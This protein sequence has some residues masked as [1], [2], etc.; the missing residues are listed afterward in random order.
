MLIPSIAT[1]R[2]LVSCVA[3]AAVNAVRKAENVRTWRSLVAVTSGNRAQTGS[4]QSICCN[5]TAETV[6]TESAGENVTA[7]SGWNDGKNTILSASEPFSNGSAAKEW[8]PIAL[9]TAS[10]V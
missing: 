8:R 10:G 3:R 1:K 6:S 7:T 2:G 9:Q 4:C 5:A